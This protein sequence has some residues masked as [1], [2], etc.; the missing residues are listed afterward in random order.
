M[1]EARNLP[2]RQTQ[3]ENDRASETERW[4]SLNWRRHFSFNGFEG[5]LSER[6]TNGDR[7]W[8]IDLSRGKK[9]KYDR[10][11]TR[12]IRHLNKSSF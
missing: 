2:V 4:S 6:R 7:G 8:R 3:P 10:E 9:S 1:E 5:T 11:S 12:S